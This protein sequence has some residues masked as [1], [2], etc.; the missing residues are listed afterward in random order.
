MPATI[1]YQ[2]F[3]GSTGDY[4]RAL[5]QRLGT[6]AQEIPADASQCE[7][8]GTDPL[9]LLSPV[10]GPSMAAADFLKHNDLGDR[11]VAVC[12]VGMTLAEEARSKD[13]CA[14]LLGRK[15]ATVTRFYLP[16]RLNYSTLSGKHRN[17]MR[18]IVGSLRLKPNKSANE[19]AMIAD[20]DRDID[21]VDLAELDPV[22]DWAL[23]ATRG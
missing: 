12:A 11:P 8:G 21:R 15:A 6:T 18:A 14:S 13:R 5:A 16:G 19:H 22:V 2:S 23:S 20:Y 3:Y 17:I 7:I 1:F 9:I 10:H 4:A